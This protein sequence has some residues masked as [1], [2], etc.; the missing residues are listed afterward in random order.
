MKKLIIALAF[1]GSI[2][3][4]NAKDLNE[5]NLKNGFINKNNIE[6]TSEDYSGEQEF[7]RD[8]TISYVNYPDTD[9]NY[10][11]FSHGIGLSQ[12]LVD[13]ASNYYNSL[14]IYAECTGNVT[15]YGT[16]QHAV[17]DLTLSDSKR[18]TLGADGMGNVLIFA[19]NTIA[20]KY[21]NTQ[22]L[23]ISFTC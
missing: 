2:T 5:N 8:G 16:Y 3:V 15:L 13:N 17:T 12:N 10:E 21:D 22:G 19:N 18:Y 4:A 11:V 14:D 1:I 7:K 23:N 20:N 9:D 6:I